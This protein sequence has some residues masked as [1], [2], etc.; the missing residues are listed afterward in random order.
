M[1]NDETQQRKDKETDENSTII[2]LLTFQKFTP[3]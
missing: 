1:V 3:L 2:S